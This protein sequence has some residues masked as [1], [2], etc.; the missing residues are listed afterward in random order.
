MYSLYMYIMHFPGMSVLI[1]LVMLYNQNRSEV[2][3]NGVEMKHLCFE[4]I[5]SCCPYQGFTV[6]MK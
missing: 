4:F 6:L 1:I 3:L 2:S 5:S